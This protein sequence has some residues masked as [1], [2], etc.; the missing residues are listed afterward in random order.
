LEF[1]F[2]LTCRA[3]SASRCRSSTEA[4]RSMGVA[5]P[6][7]QRYA[8]PGEVRGERNVAPQMRQ[9]HRRH[10]RRGSRAE[11]DEEDDGDVGE[12]QSVLPSNSFIAQGGGQHV[13]QAHRHPR[14]PRRQQ[15][16]LPRQQPR[17]RRL[18]RAQLQSRR[19]RRRRLRL[20]PPHQRTVV[21]NRISVTEIP[22]HFYCF[23]L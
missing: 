2:E 19:R 18:A 21:R 20:L 5:C 22:L 3:P 15:R 11:G 23:H 1:E 6:Q 8:A 7:L 13:P 4:S 14:N 17:R 10:G 12:S 9:G 16:Q